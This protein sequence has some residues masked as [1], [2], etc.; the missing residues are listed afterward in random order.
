MIIFLKILLEAYENINSFI[1]PEPVN[2]K[3]N[4]KTLNSIKS[5]IFKSQKYYYPNTYITI[6]ERKISFRDIN[7]N[8]VYENLKPIK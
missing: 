7:E 1:Y 3:G 5:I 6:D 4:D 2:L 8:V